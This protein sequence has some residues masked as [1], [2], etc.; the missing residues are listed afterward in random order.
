MG[1]E[2]G[3]REQEVEERVGW[4][5]EQ[6]EKKKG[7]EGEGSRWFSEL[8]NQLYQHSGW[9]PGGGGVGKITAFKIGSVFET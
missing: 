1:E 5:V 7:V 9:G 8:I 3:G 6:E 2:G 4:E